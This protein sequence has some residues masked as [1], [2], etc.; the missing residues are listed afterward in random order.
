MSQDVKDLVIIGAGPSALAAAIYTSREDIKTTMFEKA[1]VGGVTATIDM[2]DNYPGFPDGVD[3]MTL[4]EQW[5]KQAKRF[6]SDIQFGEVTK[7]EI[8]GKE[9][10]VTVDGKEVR[11]KAVLIASG[12]RYGKVGAPGEDEYFGKGV[13]YCA[14][15]DGAFY[16]GKKLAVVGGGNSAIQEAIFLTRFATHIDLIVRSYVKASAVLKRELGNMVKD[17]KI[18]VHEATTIDSINGDGAHVVSL[19]LDE[20]GKK[21]T[22]ELDGVFVFVGMKPNTEFLN[23]SNIEI[24]DEGYIRTD[25]HMMTSLDGVFASG[26]VRH[27]ATKQ[28]ASAA[29]EGVTAAI[30]IREYLHRY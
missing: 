27:G 25:E 14:T 21:S 19:S 28:I 29:G 16:F 7:I 9:K 20:N 13:H 5:E 2:I 10:V 4:S 30:A 17:G 8:D 11:A 12:R 26:D 6:G 23:N 18:T 22:L 3:G 24:T 15:C 1:V